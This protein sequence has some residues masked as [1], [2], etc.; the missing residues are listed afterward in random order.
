MD[1]GAFE[2]QF[3]ARKRW[4][5]D[6]GL[7]TALRATLP[8]RVRVVDCGA[9]VG[10]YVAALRMAGYFAV[11]VDATPNVGELSGG[12]VSYADLSRPLVWE[13]P[14]DW[15][16][17]IEVGEHIPAEYAAT[18]LDNVAAA[19]R[20]GLIVSWAVPGQRGRDHINCREPDWVAAQLAYRG[21]PVDVPATTRARD[22]AGRGWNRKLLVLTRPAA[23]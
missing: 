7:W 15:A 4:R 23:F 18:Y 12:L 14:A 20:R 5:V 19:A 8:P 6:E 3:T 1:N 21:W 16:M 2:G 10:K 9:S 11:G 17:S 13:D 22:L